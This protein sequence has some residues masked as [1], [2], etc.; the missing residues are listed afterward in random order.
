MMW[1]KDA[2]DYLHNWVAKGNAISLEQAV[3]ALSVLTSGEYST[4]IEG[5][6]YIKMSWNEYFEWM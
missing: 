1:S 3:T 4:E 5:G 6:T 2:A